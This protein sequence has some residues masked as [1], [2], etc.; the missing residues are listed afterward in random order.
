M[1][2]FKCIWLASHR[3]SGSLYVCRKVSD[4]SVSPHFRMTRAG[5][6]SFK[7]GPKPHKAFKW[8]QIADPSGRLW[9]PYLKRTLRISP[10]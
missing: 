9:A 1:L 6:M 2:P 10:Y 5:Q 7:I 3:E 4:F 8:A